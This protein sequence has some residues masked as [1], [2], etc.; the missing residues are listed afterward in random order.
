MCGI[1]GFITTNAQI[2][3]HYIEAMNKQIR[4]R[5]PD[6]EGYYL[7]SAIDEVQIVAGAD[8]ARISDE[9]GYA[10]TKLMES[11]KNDLVKLA[12][13]HRRLSIVDLSPLG[14]QPLSIDNG[15]YWI[16]YNGEVYNHLELREELEGAGYKF[17]SHSDTEVI[18]VAYQRWG[19]ECLT[20]FNGMFAFLI[21]DR[22][23]NQVFIARDR[24]G[25][26]PL[27]YYQTHDGIYFASEIKQFTVTPN[28]QAKLNHQRAYD[29][30]VH[31]LTDHT[32]ET[33]FDKVYQLRG[34][35]Y[36]L[37]DLNNLTKLDVEGLFIE[38]WYDLPKHEYKHD[39]SR[40]ANDFKNIFQDAVKLRLRA[41][42]DVGSCL[43][44]GLDSSAIVSVMAKEL[45]AQNKLHH[46]K[47]FSA[48]S[49]Q[50]EFDESEFIEEVVKQTNAES[51]YCYP[52]LE[53][54]FKLVEMISWHQDE[55][56]GSTSIFAQ[57]EVFA[58]AKQQGLK[59][60]LDGQGA[61][62][63]LAGYQGLY[64]QIYL[65]ELLHKGRL[66]SFIGELI[67]FKKKH[68]IVIKQFVL[69][70][71]LSLFPNKLKL[72]LGKLLGKM[73]YDEGWIN[74]GQLHYVA[75]DPFIG[76]GVNKASVKNTIRS[77]IC[78]SNL[79]MLLH[80]EDRDSM[81]HSIESRV[82][83]LDYRLVELI[84][85]MPTEYK[86][87]NGITKRV[88]R[89][90]LAGVLPEL[91]RTRMSKLGFATPEEVWVRE[92]ADFFKEQLVQSLVYCD[93]LL[94]KEKVLAIFDEIIAK[95]RQFDFWLWRVISFGLW[96]KLFKV[97]R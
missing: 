53:E 44:G 94:N 82:P 20:K 58:L 36:S 89:D 12:F 50:K 11:L 10:P 88:L 52:E 68:A 13:A 67:Q 34:G 39:F 8:S 33:M 57:W 18:L 9:F 56:F 85:S 22:L 75:K 7:V 26:K 60:M 45:A 41:D 49:K 31:G 37:I 96:M 66:F 27:Y 46:L 93:D 83:F 17:I 62:E 87:K 90:G 6:D 65:N 47:T 76:T 40:A 5:G 59:V 61:D 77:Q 69:K 38:R 16:S 24:F 73:Q 2:K 79:P 63:Q 80:F 15:D 42:V 72:K 19:I 78:Y 95:E 86:I 30:L 92:H 91:I 55:P 1:T 48:A 4:H 70:S 84:F 23:K 35:E 81:A 32:S 97:R 71:L 29:F 21:H 51:F 74:K 14:H 25:V 64:F 54:L 43:S 28:W 3:A